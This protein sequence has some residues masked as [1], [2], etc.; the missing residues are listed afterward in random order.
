MRNSL[1]LAPRAK[2]SCAAVYCY[3]L[4]KILRARRSTR[5]SSPLF[6]LSDPFSTCADFSS[7][8]A[9]LPPSH[10]RLSINFN[11]YMSRLESVIIALLFDIYE[12]G[13]LIASCFVQVKCTQFAQSALLFAEQ[14]MSNSAI[15]CFTIMSNFSADL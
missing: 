14:L 4:C 8:M 12:L 11:F 15:I 7:L 5:S 2:V 3:I 10:I 9:C 6:L 1:A 13:L